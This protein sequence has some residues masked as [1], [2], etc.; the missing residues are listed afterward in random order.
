MTAMF[1]GATSFLFGKTSTELIEGGHPG[2]IKYLRRDIDD[3]KEYNE[4]IENA[5]II[6]DEKTNN[7]KVISAADTP[8]YNDFLTEIEAGT[9][10]LYNIKEHINKDGSIGPYK[11][12]ITITLGDETITH[13][14]TQEYIDE[15]T[16]INT[17][18]NTP[19]K[20]VVSDFDVYTIGTYTITLTA[21]STAGQGNTVTATRTVNVVDTTAPTM[22]IT[23]TTVSSGAT[24]ND[25]SI[26]LTFISSEATTN[27]TESL[28][29]SSVTSNGFLYNFTQD[30]PTVYTARVYTPIDGLYTVDVAAGA[31]TDAAGNGNTAALQFT[32]TY[33]R[34][35]PIITITSTTVSS[36]ATSNDSS[37]QLTFLLSE[38][39]YNL[40]IFPEIP[41]P[42]NLTNI[43]ESSNGS[44]SNFTMV[45]LTE[46]TATLTPTTDGLYTVDVA[47][48]AFTD[49]TGNGNYAATKFTWRYDSTPPTMEITSTTV[50][51]GATSNDAS[52]D[53]TFTPSESTTNFDV[54][55]ITVTNGLLSNF[56][57]P[58]PYDGFNITRI[59]NNGTNPNYSSPV[60][61][62]TFTIWNSPG[63]D[64][65][66]AVSFTNGN[67]FTLGLDQYTDIT[68]QSNGWLQ[69]GSSST[70]WSESLSLLVNTPS[71]AIPWDDYNTSPA[72][73]T[74]IGYKYSADNTQFIVSYDTH[75]WGKT[76]D[77]QIMVTLNLDSHSEP[78]TIRIDYGK[79]ENREG[80]VGV[81]YGLG[82]SVS[83]SIE[84]D[85]LTITDPV[86]VAYP[87]IPHKDYGTDIRNF[88][89]KTVIFSKVF[90]EFTATLTPSEQGLCRVDVA[91]GAFT[92][93]AGNGN[94][95]APQFT[96]TYVSTST[97][98]TLGLEVDRFGWGVAD[99]VMGG[100]GDDSNTP[101][102]VLTLTGELPGAHLGIP[103]VTN[104]GEL[105]VLADFGITA[106]P[107][108]RQYLISLTENTLV[109]EINYYSTYWWT[110]EYEIVAGAF[111]VDLTSLEGT[112]WKLAQKE[113]ALKVGDSRG[114]GESWQTSSQDL[115]TRSSIFDDVIKFNA[116]GT[117]EHFMQGETWVEEWQD[118]LPD[119]ARAPVA[120]H[121]GTD[122]MRVFEPRTD[123]SGNWPYMLVASLITDGDVSQ[124]AQ[125]FTMIVDSLPEGG[126]NFRVFKTFSDFN[127]FFGNAQPLTL[128][129]NT[130]TVSAVSFNRAVKFHFSSGDIS[131][132][133]VSLNGVSL[134]P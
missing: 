107:E 36:G 93:A 130:F 61:D 37:I 101:G 44:L 104:N 103:K 133:S 134:F 64:A 74:G 99:G 78:G 54:L 67:T 65:T 21:T 30:S 26:D 131:F 70:F 117:F 115:V 87:N 63:D 15:A 89:Y 10:A 80:L 120:P 127:G 125:T 29:N 51:S 95:A 102:T 32:W 94:I 129:F 79:L 24:S 59:D 116:D 31:F 7:L 113:G 90:Q 69:F 52:I 121:N 71:I 123:E 108:S 60:T 72:Q 96:W 92:D 2:F 4:L 85:Y 77:V 23:S 119:G 3:D 48:G 81:S 56:I 20:I 46:Y 124:N 105:D 111:P 34:T 39:P 16:A 97:V 19:V 128:G 66:L 33:D 68:L 27:F 73:T 98:A 38:Q 132:S 49:A 91:A 13:E 126:A 88:Q 122:S 6:I 28:F 17:D 84:I 58:I 110:F 62:N 76:N 100:T 14:R 57:S 83:T 118:G 114:S 75:E 12:N 41:N 109:A 1:L 35:G 86:F 25:A 11:P 50:S 45:S 55:D 18:I 47:A 43:T 82:S 112:S 22:T 106:V 8:Y 40:S 42:L 9:M 5:V 53:L